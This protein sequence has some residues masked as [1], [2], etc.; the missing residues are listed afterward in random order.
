MPSPPPDFSPA[1]D[2]TQED[3][4]RFAPD[5]KA[6]YKEA[7]LS[8]AGILTL[9]LAGIFA[10]GR[11]LSHF[12]GQCGAETGGFTRQR[13]SLVYTSVDR[14]KAV[15]PQ[16]SKVEIKNGRGAAF[17]ETLLRNPVGLGDWAYGGRLG[18]GK[19]TPE[20]PHHDGFDFRGGGWLQVTGRANVAAFCQKLGVA[21]RSDILDDPLATLRFAC[22][23]WDERGCNALADADDLLGLSRAINLGNAKSTGDPN[24]LEERQAWTEKAKAVWWEREASPIWSV[25]DEA[26]ANVRARVE[27][28]GTLQSGNVGQQETTPLPGPL[29][30]S[31]ER[32]QTQ[33]WETGEPVFISG[34]SEEGEKMNTAPAAARAG[35]GLRAILDIFGTIVRSV[36]L[37]MAAIA[38]VFNIIANAF[39]DWL[40][41]LWDFV[42]WAVG[43]LPEMTT[44][45]R[46]TLTS[47][48]E[49]AKWFKVDW[50]A[51]GL[52][53]AVAVVAV[54]FVRHYRVKTEVEG[55][56]KAA[57]P[58]AS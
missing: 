2:L 17:L 21:V 47:A 44:E 45:V 31:G 29:P 42:L 48:E 30:A 36:S 51:V 8:E 35:G 50:P 12:L 18:N 7:L 26:V 16:R 58:S 24:G 37:V 53:V 4:A 34:P 54:W 39:T 9:A 40:H 28:A 14:I 41:A 6:F 11:R 20:A 57:E 46:T 25:E 27:A 56:R 15:W 1:I 38:A 33:G 5:M 13:E 32:E 49:A 10:N 22:A 55:H 23:Y 52:W 3:L 19:G 43:A